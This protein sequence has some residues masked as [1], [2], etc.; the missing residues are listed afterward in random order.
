MET[1]IVRVGGGELS[2]YGGFVVPA[3]V[4]DIGEEAIEHFVNFFTAEIKNPNTRA[5][6]GMAVAKFLRGCELQGLRL[7]EI[8]PVTVAGYIE[9][10]PLSVPSVKLHLAGIKRFFD[11]MVVKQVMPASPAVSVRGPKY[12]QA[13]GKTPYL[14]AEETRT[15][16]DAIDTSHVIGLRDRAIVALMVLQFSRVSA[17]INM[18]VKDYYC[19]GKRSHFRFFGKGGE[20]FSMP[21]HHKAEEF[22]DEY[23]DAARIRDERNGPLF[24]RVGKHGELTLEPLTR[25]A[26][27]KMVKRRARAVGLPENIGCHSFRATAITIYRNNGGSLDGAQRLARHK[28]SKT[29]QLYDHSGDEI[30]LDEVER[31]AV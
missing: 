18:Q 16:L 3:I 22:T 31:V 14:T 26:V 5:A 15:L 20:E 2:P 8:K 13:I 17:L 4:A 21:A 25:R 10:L 23:L 11:Y 19:Q 6:Y 30:T 24:R 28:Q 9:T 29:T 1:A 27:L 7:R 12:S